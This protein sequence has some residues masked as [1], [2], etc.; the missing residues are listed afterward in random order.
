[1]KQPPGTHWTGWVNPTAG[2]DDMEKIFDP[3]GTQT[4]THRPAVASL[5]TDCAI[6]APE[7]MYRTKL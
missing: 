6:L 4:L 2:L 3:T 5:Y 1:M 7:N